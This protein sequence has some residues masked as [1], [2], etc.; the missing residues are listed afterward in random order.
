MSKA[1][2][3]TDRGAGE[4]VWFRLG[5]RGHRACPGKVV[6]ALGLSHLEKIA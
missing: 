3:I 1:M 2:L 5:Q 4:G 6:E